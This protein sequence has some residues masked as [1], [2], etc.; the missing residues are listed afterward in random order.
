MLDIRGTREPSIIRLN[1]HPNTNSNDLTIR[2]EKTYHF[3]KQKK[4]TL[5]CNFKAIPTR[6]LDY[7]YRLLLTS[8]RFNFP[9]KL[10]ARS[11]WNHLKTRQKWRK[12]WIFHA[13]HHNPL[14]SQEKSF[15]IKFFLLHR[16][17]LLGT[18]GAR[19]EKMFG[20]KSR[21]AVIRALSN[22]R[23]ISASYFAVTIL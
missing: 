8:T 18:R 22:S 15:G 4:K 20:L 5:R 6:F 9:Y 13:D 17:L 3:S 7:T 19:I 12:R 11:R 21:N 2:F 23:E 1:V 16:S 14:Y 10:V